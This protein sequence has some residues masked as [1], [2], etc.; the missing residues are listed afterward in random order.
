VTGLEP[1]DTPVNSSPA[2]SLLAE[3]VSDGRSP[4]PPLRQQPSRHGRDVARR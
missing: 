4:A 1:A 2:R 3:A